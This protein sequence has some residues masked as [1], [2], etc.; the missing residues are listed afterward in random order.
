MSEAQKSGSLSL[1]NLPK[2]PGTRQS[3]KR[4]G[5]GAGSHGRYSTK[6]MNGQK[7]RSGRGKGPKFNSGAIPLYRRL[8]KH[9]GFNRDWADR[10][11]VINLADLDRLPEGTRIEPAALVSLGL[12]R[13]LDQPVKLLGNG[14]LKRPV[15]ISVHA[16]SK[17]ALAAIQQVGG[18]LH[19]LEWHFKGKP[20]VKA[21]RE[22]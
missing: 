4:L 1:G 18:T 19:L 5:R 3:K 8:P 20:I 17:T 16:A 7:Q 9:R 12:I 2:D 22:Q 6:G 21:G 15:E 14:E 10:Y 11:Q 13:T